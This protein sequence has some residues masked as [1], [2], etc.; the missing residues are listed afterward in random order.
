[1]EAGAVRLRL[2]QLAQALAVLEKSRLAW[3]SDGQVAG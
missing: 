2:G 1:M 3:P